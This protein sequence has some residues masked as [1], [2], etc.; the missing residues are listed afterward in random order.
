[1]RVF[2]TDDESVYKEDFGKISGLKKV[3]KAEIYNKFDTVQGQE[4]MT[5]LL[6]LTSMYEQAKP[7]SSRVDFHQA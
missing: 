7:K 5:A 4:I 1:M 3:S 6:G 2:N